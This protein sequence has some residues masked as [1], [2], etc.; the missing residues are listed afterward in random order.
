[1][2]LYIAG[3]CSEHGRNAFLVS[4]EKVSFIVDAGIMKEKA[5]TPWPEFTDEQVKNASFLFLTHSHTDHTGAVR[6]LIK[7]GFSGTI[8]ASRQTFRVL[9][10]FSVQTLCI[11]DAG[12]PGEEITVNEHLRMMWGRS[13]HCIGSVWYRFAAE[14]SSI[15]FSG[16]YEY[17]SYAYKCDDICGVTADTGV[18]DCAYGNEKEDAVTHF[19][20]LKTVMDHYTRERVPML[21]PVPS[22]G[23]GLD[24]LRLLAERGIPVTADPAVAE[25]IE[26]IR[27]SAFWL[28]DSF[29]TAV[30]DIRFLP[31][32]PLRDAVRDGCDAGTFRNLIGWTGIL[33]RDSQ[34]RDETNQLLAQ[35]VSNA[36]G[37][38]IL[39]GKQDPSSYARR[40]YDE[41]KADF[42][43]ISVH[44]NTDEMLKLAGRN[45][46]G[47]VIPYHCR[48]KLEFDRDDVIVLEPGDRIRIERVR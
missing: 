19:E 43:R 18:L 8:Y 16:D 15:L 13:G 35:Y 42:C 24:V 5:G 3:G 46:F 21:F 9:Q 6:W 22:H 34:L 45:D 10:E 25:E 39:T 48:Q 23:R 1:M 4:G 47:T 40:L 29:I 38:V 27:E 17:R 12:G 33:V 28:Q 14:G 37:R 7:R 11:D 20:Y 44:Q 30:E 26:S 32:T 41:G 36:G 2:E 31:L